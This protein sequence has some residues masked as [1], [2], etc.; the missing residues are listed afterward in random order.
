[1]DILEYVI[2]DICEVML[3]LPYAIMAGGLFG[4]LYLTVCFV[5]KHELPEIRRWMVSTRWSYM[6]L[7]CCRLYFLAESQAVGQEWI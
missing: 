6:V 2:A 7:Y 5:R 1:M 4:L 3:Y